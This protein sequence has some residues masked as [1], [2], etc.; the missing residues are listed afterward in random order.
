MFRLSAYLL[1]FVLA[2]G[3]DVNALSM[4]STSPKSNG[5][6]TIP[7]QPSSRK[8]FLQSSAALLPFVVASPAFAAKEV[9][10]AVK[11]TKADPAYQN[12]V[13]QCLY[14]CTKPKGDEQKS[15]QECIPECKKQCATDKQ[16]LMIG[17]PIK[18][19]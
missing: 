11:G 17:T 13:S 1:S 10:P 16:Q 8:A 15:R 2:V 14:D 5:I 12:C 4:S 19:E 18:K 9:D 6:N 7:E 3:C